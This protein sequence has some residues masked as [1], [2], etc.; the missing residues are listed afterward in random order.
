M[1]NAF[2]QNI[3]LGLQHGSYNTPA[4]DYRPI[5]DA[6]EIETVDR[7]PYKYKYNSKEWQDELGLDWY[8]YGARNYDAS[9]GRWMNVDRLSEKYEML[10]PYAYVANNPTKF[11]D[12]NGEWIYIEDK[13]GTRYRYDNG[14][15]QHK[16]DDKW[17]AIDET[18][19]LSD[20]VLN[21][22]AGVDALAR[23]GNTGYG[24]VD[25]F[26]N[27]QKNVLFKDTSRKGNSNRGGQIIVDRRFRGAITPIEGGRLERGPFYV[28]IGHELAHRIDQ[29]ERYSGKDIYFPWITLSDGQVSRVSEK[30]ATHIENMIRSESGLPLRTHYA[31]DSNR[32]MGIE[33]TRVLDSNCKSLYFNQPTLT[34]L[35]NYQESIILRVREQNVKYDYRK[36]NP[37]P[38]VN[39]VK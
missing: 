9:L 8:D 14:Q 22:V 19:Q 29:F 20:Y 12:I 13:D 17:V 24:V 5:G 31:V 18:V 7:N 4:R 21:V 11:I 37:V 36:L 10:S 1:H 28:A 2:L 32:N 35:F 38:T 6:R 39:S 26:S 33:A 30:F 23:S 25:Y 16:V 34:T 27:D 15:T 3:T